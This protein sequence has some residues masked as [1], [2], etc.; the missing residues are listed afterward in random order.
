MQLNY[1]KAPEQTVDGE[2]VAMSTNG[3]YAIYVVNRVEREY[4]QEALP[5]Y[6]IV[7]LS[8][9]AMEGRVSNL[10]LAIRVMQ[11]FD[12]RLEQVLTGEDEEEVIGTPFEMDS[13]VSLN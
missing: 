10:A 3:H 5:R 1:T 8:T 2:Q 7:N 9:L 6:E 4:P 12:A 13:K 11:E